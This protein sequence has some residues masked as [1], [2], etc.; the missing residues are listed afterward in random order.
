ML[1][2]ELVILIECVCFSMHM[3]LYVYV[4]TFFVVIDKVVCSWL[5]VEEERFYKL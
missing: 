3:Y 4:G 1:L 5:L 2:R